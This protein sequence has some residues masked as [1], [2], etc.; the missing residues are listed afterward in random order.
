MKVLISIPAYNEENDLERVIKEIKGVMDNKYNYSIQVIDD[1]STD[2][3]VEVA[4]KL[5]AKV[6]THPRN[7]GLAEAFKTEIK[8][9]LIGFLPAFVVLVYGKIAKKK[10]GI[11]YME[12]ASEYKDEK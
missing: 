2:K 12:L 3:T 10:N 9:C 8:E 5:G 11:I 7:L 4:K 6:Y 1:G